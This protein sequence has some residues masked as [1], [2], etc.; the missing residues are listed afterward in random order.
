MDE[1]A[2]GMYAYISSWKYLYLLYFPGGK[3]LTLASHIIFIFSLK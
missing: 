1:E 2:G 3:L